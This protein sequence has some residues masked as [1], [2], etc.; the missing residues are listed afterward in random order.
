MTG[1]VNGNR[2][3]SILVLRF[4]P[5]KKHKNME[6]KS[7]VDESLREPLGAGHRLYGS[8]SRVP[9]PRQSS[10]FLK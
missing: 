1:R 8:I 5:I 9:V 3:G 2:H 6:K 4:S 7:R 10:I